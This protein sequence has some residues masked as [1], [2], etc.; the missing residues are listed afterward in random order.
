MTPAL[1]RVCFRSAIVLL[2]GIATGCLAPADKVSLGQTGIG[3]VPNVQFQA[4]RTAM[5][6][7]DYQGALEAYQDGLKGAIRSA[8]TRWVDS[9]AFH[10]MIGECLYQRGQLPQALDQFNAAID[11][12]NANS[13]WLLSI[14][15]PAIIDP[16]PVAGVATPWG[17]PVEAVLPG[18]FAE[19]YNMVNNTLGLQGAGIG[20]SGNTFLVQG[21]QAIPIRCSEIVRAVCTAIRR[22]RQIMGPLCEFDP[23]TERL[24]NALS[25]RPAAPNHWSQCWIEVQLGCAFAASGKTPQAIAEL[26]KS[27]KAGEVYYHPLTATAFNELGQLAMEEGKYD[28]AGTCFMEATYVAAAFGIVE[29]MDEAFRGAQQAWLLSGSGEPF[30]PLVPAATWAKKSDYDALHASILLLAGENLN[31]LGRTAEA[32]AILQQ[33]QREI[34]RTDMQ[35]ARLGAR[36]QFEQARLAFA[37]GNQAPGVTALTSALKFQQSASPWLFQIDMATRFHGEKV[38]SDRAVDLI[39]SYLLRDPMAADWSVQPFDTLAVSSSDYQAAYQRWLEV[40]V[41]RKDHDRALEVADRMKRHRFYASLPLGGRLPALRMVLESPVTGLSPRTQTQRT[42]LLQ[43]YPGYEPLMNRAEEIRTSLHALPLMP[44]DRAQKEQQTKLLHELTRVSE[45]QETILRNMAVRREAADFIMPPA[46]TLAEFR[47]R[48]TS[49]Q[50]VLYYASTS[51]AS[52]GFA[53]TKDKLSTFQIGVPSKVKADITAL[54]KEIGNIDKNGNVSAETMGSSNWKTIAK[55]LLKN[56][57]NNAKDDSWSH[58]DEVIIV[59]EGPLWY[60]PFE[61]LVA[62]DGSDPAPLISQTR[63]RYAPTLGLALPDSMGHRGEGRTAVVTGKLFPRDDLT[64]AANAFEEVSKST[65][66]AERIAQQTP[67]ASSVFSSI[68]DRV[69]VF[70]DIEDPGKGGPYAWSPLPVDR[71]RKGTDLSE[72]MA[73]PMAGPNLVVLPGFH[74]AAETAIKKPASG[75]DIFLST[76]ALMSSGSQTVLISR[77]RPGGKTAYDLVREFVQEQPNM[78]ASE[79]WQRSVQLAMASPVVFKDEP[80]IKSDSKD[81]APMANHP[82]FWAAYCLVDRGSAP[83]QE[84]ATPV[85]IPDDALKPAAAKAGRDDRDEMPADKGGKKP[86]AKAGEKKPAAGEA[87]MDPAADV[88]GKKPKAGVAGGEDDAI[89]DG[90]PAAEP[91]KPGKKPKVKPGNKK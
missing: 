8:D 16:A 62:G 1:R 41:A 38:I 17:T 2:F 59:P 18:R 66:Q 28:Q 45:E 63:I 54:L 33:V 84:P 65:A 19:R 29:E 49:R 39:Y 57:S 52:Y 69:V 86:A 44:E 24:A 34:N 79:A 3:Q 78:A 74:T 32:D 68:C 70:Q 6:A 58:Y 77:W 88:G 9:A 81:A 26:T 14:E 80:R 37:T 27:L 56:L 60:L 11:I 83:G 15:F 20:N 67:V 46:V 61:C 50:L 12:F 43:N 87:K 55:R 53:L 40:L 48:L 47:K 75:E 64:V 5:V 76:C 90:P 35:R 89:M 13:N 71:S 91:G 10:A 21:R 31:L 42:M 82:F 36:L 51:N 72:W 22:R 85:D 7:G 73:L 25:A 23:R 30:A 4:G